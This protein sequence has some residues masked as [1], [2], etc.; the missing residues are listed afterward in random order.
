MKEHFDRWLSRHPRN[1]Y[2]RTGREVSGIG[3]TIF[4][5]YW[6]KWPDADTCKERLIELLACY[7][8]GVIANEDEESCDT[9]WEAVTGVIREQKALSERMI[10]SSV[11]AAFDAAR[12]QRMARPGYSENDSWR[13][14]RVDGYA[15][16]VNKFAVDGVPKSVTEWSRDRLRQGH[17]YEGHIDSITALR[18]DVIARI[19]K[20]INPV[21][22]SAIAALIAP[23]NAPISGVAPQERRHAKDPE[24]STGQGTT[25]TSSP[26]D[27]SPTM[28]SELSW[29][30]TPL[31]ARCLADFGGWDAITWKKK[32]GDPPNWMCAD[33]L[34]RRGLPGKRANL[35]QPVLLI[36]VIVQRRPDRKTNVDSARRRFAN[37]ATLKPWLDAWD[38][39]SALMY[40]SG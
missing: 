25:E 8:D 15:C 11:M 7:P 31:M 32:L 14:G 23:P 6:F 27:A 12:R 30:P 20:T 18:V 28:G 24:N 10:P 13:W 1:Q 19:A 35:W 34:F 37:G 38:A 39:H 26:A 4:K 40:P 33:N 21:L 36:D 5:T 16:F 29:I 9:I 3:N 22:E 2:R 17:D